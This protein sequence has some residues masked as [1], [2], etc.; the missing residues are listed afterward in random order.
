VLALFFIVVIFREGVEFAINAFIRNEKAYTAAMW[1]LFP[2][3]ALVCLGSFRFMLQI[4]CNIALQ[5]SSADSSTY[6]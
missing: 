6:K 4:L 2:A 3:Y 5:L 1:P